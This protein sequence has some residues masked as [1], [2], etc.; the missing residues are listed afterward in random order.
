[1]RS[2]VEKM[3]VRYKGGKLDVPE[4]DTTS[5]GLNRS[6]R[7]KLTFFP[8]EPASW[9]EPKKQN[10]I[11]GLSDPSGGIKEDCI[12]DDRSSSNIQVLDIVSTSV[13]LRSLHRN[14]HKSPGYNWDYELITDSG[15]NAFLVCERRLLTKIAPLQSKVRGIDDTFLLDVKGQEG[16]R[17]RLE[18]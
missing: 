11:L 3:G 17:L 1:M 5:V 15:A 12:S 16:L 7:N 18:M 2:L 9:S 13:V 4:E 6:Y 10:L 8:S 14:V